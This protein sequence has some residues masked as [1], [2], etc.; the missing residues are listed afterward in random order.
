MSTS[1]PIRRAVRYALLTGTVAT[2]MTA[3]PAGAQDQAIAEVVVTGSRIRVNDLDTPRP[4]VMITRDAIEQQGFQSVTEILQN[5]SAAGSPALTRASPLSAGENA[6]G[7]FISLRGL[8]AQRTLTLVDGQRLGISTSGFQDISGIP[9]AMIERIEVLKDGASSLYG[10][11][12]IGGVINII[13]RKKFDGIEG[14]AYVGQ[15]DDGDGTI[16]KYDFLLGSV[17]ERSSL[18]FGAEYATE[19]AVLAKDRPFSAFPQGERHPDRNWTTVGQFGGFVRGGV[20]IIPGDGLDPRNI[21]NW[22]NQNTNTGATA[23]SPEGSPL[24]KSNTNQQ[25]DLRT[26]LERKSVYLNG[27]YAISEAVEFVGSAAYTNRF[28]DR[29]VA[30]YPY[31]AASFNT[32]MSI[33]SYFNPI[34]NQS[35]TAAPAAIGNW[36]RRGWEVPRVSSSDVDALRF[37]AGLN[38]DFEF[39]NR[40]FAWDVGYLFS[41]TRATQSAFGNLN[42]VAVRNAVGPSFLNAQGQVQCGTPAAPINFGTTDGTCTPWNPFLPFGVEGPGGLTNNAALQQYLFQEEHSSGDTQ[43]QLFTANI[44]GNIVSLPAGD[45]A[46]ALGFERREESGKFIPDALS[47]TGNSTNLGALPTE[48]GYNVNEVYGELFIP[49]LADI[50]VFQEL[51]LNASTRYSDYDTFGNTTNSKFGLEWRPIQQVLLRGTYAEG[52]RAPT[53][54]NLF[55]GGSQTFSFY[56]DPC[57]PV[58]GAAAT[59][60]SVASTCAADIANYAAFRQLGQGFLPA[61]GPNTQTPVAFF[62]GAANPLLEPEE[63]ESKS[64]GIVWTPSFVSGLQMSF[65]WWTIRIDNTIVA[66]LPTDILNDCYVQNIADRCSPALFTRDPTLGFV[67]TMRFGSRNAGFREVEGYDF[68][69][70]YSFEAGRFG[71]FVLNL[72]STYLDRDAIATNDAA[73]TIPDEDVGFAVQAKTTH[74]VRA[75]ANVTWTLGDFGV[76]WGARYYS[77][78]RERCLNAG[79]FPGECSDPTYVGPTPQQSGAHN[80]LG[81][82][83]FHDVQVRWNTPWNGTLAL[84]ANNVFEHLGQP[85]YSQ[86]NANV[87]Y[88]GEFDIGRFVYARYRQD[89]GGK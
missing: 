56:T 24:D 81:S 54:A 80:E 19:D 17:G 88:N 48:G 58:F 7:S 29:T 89:F 2:L 55:A 68:D 25:T 74:R 37:S 12:A 32:P 21:A 31:Q 41:N 33:D 22:R 84:G 3:L 9:S 10:S 86:P 15:Y 18:T 45:L 43:T 1:N 23:A 35:G 65:D 8:G 49:V 77:G 69:A 70:N 64:A 66:D 46:F 85:M 83:I 4:V 71:G 63:S 26:P 11:D 72:Q 51:N 79:L 67:N 52:F 16:Q 34:G 27:T 6:G 14:N 59:N 36:W 38:G 30:G 60:G 5:V 62:Q 76:T 44:T 28:S 87:S 20:R 57:D 39:A 13:T 53:I 47:V 78:L 42:L 75:N 61:G 50:P 82:N 73:T 40:E